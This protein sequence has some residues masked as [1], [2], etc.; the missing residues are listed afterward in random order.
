MPAHRPSP[1]W[2][3]LRDL[4]LTAVTTAAALLSALLFTLHALQQTRN[5]I[6]LLLAN[7]TVMLAVALGGIAVA[8]GLLYVLLPPPCQPPPDPRIRDSLGS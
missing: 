2:A 5:W 7:R 1:R 8:A 6:G 3:R 4:L